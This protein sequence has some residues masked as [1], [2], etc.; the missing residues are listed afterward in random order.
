MD[1]TKLKENLFG[2]DISLF[3]NMI[4]FA[5]YLQKIDDAPNDIR[6]KAY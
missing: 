6:L 5:F 4:L 2:L 1:L 3:A